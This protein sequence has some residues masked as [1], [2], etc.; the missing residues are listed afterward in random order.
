MFESSL[1][2]IAIK[3]AIFFAF[4]LWE[5]LKIILWLWKDNS[6]HWVYKKRWQ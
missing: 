4:P 2:T 1:K 5:T 6:G 3:P